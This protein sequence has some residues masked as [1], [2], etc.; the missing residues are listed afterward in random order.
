MSTGFQWK[1]LKASHEINPAYLSKFIKKDISL[2]SIVQ[3]DKAT[4]KSAKELT[5]HIA[6][7]T[8]H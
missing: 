3:E 1:W 6:F 8:V 5:D 4:A 7:K 2:T